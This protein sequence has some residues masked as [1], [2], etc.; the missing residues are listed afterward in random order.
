M[1]SK[2]NLQLD[3]ANGATTKMSNK[4]TPPTG[5]FLGASTETSNS[6]H[7]HATNSIRKIGDWFEAEN[8]GKRARFWA[9]LA[10]YFGCFAADFRCSSLLVF[11][12][13]FQLH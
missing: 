12:C 9:V 11:H 2:L 10:A 8:L 4:R 6:K 5:N 1:N 7:N 3:R 13:V